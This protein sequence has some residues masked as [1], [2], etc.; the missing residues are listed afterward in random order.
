MREPF[1]RSK[2]AMSEPIDGLLAVRDA[3]GDCKATG[4]GEHGHAARRPR[5]EQALR[6]QTSS[7]RSSLPVSLATMLVIV[8][9]NGSSGRAKDH[10]GRPFQRLRTPIYQHKTFWHTDVSINPCRPRRVTQSA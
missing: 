10:V 7:C 8:R 9:S 2:E 6:T 1:V 4:D 3:F 5:D